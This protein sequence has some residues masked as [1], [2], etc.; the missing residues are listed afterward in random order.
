[1]ILQIIQEKLQSIFLKYYCWKSRF[2]ENRMFRFFSKRW[3]TILPNH[4]W[5]K[6]SYAN[7]SDNVH[8]SP[9]RIITYPRIHCRLFIFLTSWLPILRAECQR[10]GKGQ[11]RVPRGMPRPTA[12]GAGRGG[13]VRVSQ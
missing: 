8:R 3:D 4:I 9:F 6:A 11:G 13:G 1:M 2:G 7:K 12:P 5:V 10:V